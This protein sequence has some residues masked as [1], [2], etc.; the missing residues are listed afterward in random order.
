MVVLVRNCT[1]KVGVKLLDAGMDVS[2]LTSVVT[3]TNVEVA[4]K[5]DQNSDTP[6]MLG[7]GYEEGV[8]LNVLRSWRV[9]LNV[10]QCC[11]HCWA[12]LDFL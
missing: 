6:T 5:F 4:W 11:N 9:N 1:V 8:G 3:A 7:N 12:V 10:Y 2:T